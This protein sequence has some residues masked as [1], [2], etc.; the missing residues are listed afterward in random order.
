VA[1]PAFVR[2]MRPQRTN[3]PEP[4]VPPTPRERRSR[5][6]RCRGTELHEET[7]RSSS[8]MTSLLLRFIC[9]PK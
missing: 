1:G 2:A 5:R 6:V 8:I 4:T 3:I 7:E 9:C